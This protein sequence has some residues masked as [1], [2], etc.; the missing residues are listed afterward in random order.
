M[1]LDA[2]LESFSNV[3]LLNKSALPP[4]MPVLVRCF[5]YL[6]GSA[7]YWDNLPVE[8]ETSTNLLG[9]IISW[10][11]RNGVNLLEL[12]NKFGG[13]LGSKD[14]IIYTLHMGYYLAC[15]WF[16]NILGLC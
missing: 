12:Q 11:P 7:G 9:F 2:T 13:K 16:P 6:K 8:P 10:A 5:L 4:S 1:S 14:I 3:F 15:I